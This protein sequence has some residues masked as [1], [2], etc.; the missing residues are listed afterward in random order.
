MFNNYYIRNIRKTVVSYWGLLRLSMLLKL[1]NPIYVA[2]GAA[3]IRDTGWIDTEIEYLNIINEKHWKRVF[4]ENSIDAL[5]AEHVWEHLTLEE[6]SM[7]A[8]YCYKYLKPGGYLRTAVPDG[9]HPNPE[10]IDHVRVLGTEGRDQG[11]KV[12]YNYI[13]FSHLFEA[14]GFKAHLLE[15]FDSKHRFYFEDWSPAKGLIRRS[16]RFDRRNSDHQLNYTSIII[17][18]QKPF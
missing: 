13:T 14:V 1:D 8:R 17:D 16:K 10:Y 2:V 12:L 4:K 3:G 9:F 7:A 11:H 18:A 5:L 6:G 15:Y